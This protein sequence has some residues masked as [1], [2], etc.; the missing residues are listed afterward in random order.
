MAARNRKIRH[1]DETRAKIQAALIIKRLQ[2]HVLGTVELQPSQVSSAKVLLD[3]VL[4]NL[5]ATELSGA[6]EQRSVMRMPE[7]AKAAEEWKPQAKPH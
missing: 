4:P 2:D 7:P 5:Q 3:K 6:V 1:D